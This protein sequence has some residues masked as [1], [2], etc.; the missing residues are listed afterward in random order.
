MT[1]SGLFLGWPELALFAAP[2]LGG[3]LLLYLLRP[4]RRQVAVPVGGLWQK[5]LQESEARVLGRQWRRIL[6]LLLML[7]LAGLLLASLA[8]PLLFPEDAPKTAV[9][10][11]PHVAIVV[12]TSASMATLDAGPEATAADP[13]AARS[14]LDA[15]VAAVAALVDAAPSE[16]RFLLLGASGHVAVHAGWGADRAALK[17]ALLRIRTNSAGFDLRR[18]CE[19]AAQALAGRAGARIVVVSDGGRARDGFDPQAAAVDGKTTFPGEVPPVQRVWVGPAASFVRQ[20]KAGPEI[21]AGPVFPQGFSNLAIEQVRVRPNAGDAARGT[22]TVRVRNDAT[23][24]VAAQLLL[25]GSA[26]AQTPGEF[27]RDEALRRLHEILLPPG[28]STH[29]V[30]DVDLSAPRFAVRI[31][32]RDAVNAMPGQPQ[33]GSPV[34]DRTRDLAPYDDW[35]FAVLAERR[36]LRVLLVTRARNLFLEA[37]LL[38]S[39]RIRI[40]AIEGSAQGGPQAGATKRPVDAVMHAADYDPAAWTAARRGV[41]GIDVV[42]LDQVAAPLPDGMPGLVLSLAPA[43][44]ATEPP[45]VYA[46]APEIVIAAAGHPLVRGVSFEDTNF[47]RVRLLRPAPGD[48][49]VAAARGRERNQAKGQGSRAVML[50]QR[51]PVRTVHWG[52]DLEE[53]DLGGRYA[54]PI[55][56]DNAVAW[57]AGEDEP[58]VAPVEPGRPWAVEAPSLGPWRYTEPGQAPRPARVSGVQLLA[59]SEVQGVH[60]WTDP[61]RREVARPTVLA[62]G[63][64]PADVTVSGTPWRE[65][66]VPTLDPS[67]KAALPPWS[68]LVLIAGG[69]LTAEWLLY[70]RRRTL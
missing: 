43:P 12:D 6:S 29:A 14:R 57:L 54:L 63:E 13:L 38:A 60:V 65:L 52:L 23:V 55:L 70:L 58:L 56:I 37:A 41:H 30:P 17:A 47:D 11:G 10:A 66:P 35:G 20:G 44:T 32:A 15:A 39:D 25:A 8:N 51:L 18:A 40:G 26:T 33:Q 61:H 69:L 59:S 24:P 9:A 21:V 49:L 67:Q 36:E 27:E 64:G 45:P 48:V 1:P 22:L 34:A 50:A 5:V 28:T 31:R 19:T 68:I 46:M 16:A 42:V 3:L 2:F 62:P 53:T 4:R 7:G